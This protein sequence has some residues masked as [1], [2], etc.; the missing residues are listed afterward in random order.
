MINKAGK[1]LPG[2]WFVGLFVSDEDE[3]LYHIDDNRAQYFKL[4]YLQTLD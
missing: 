4:F 2:G 1:G 3:M